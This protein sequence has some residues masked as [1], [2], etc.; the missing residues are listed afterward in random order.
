MY[1]SP[2]LTPSLAF[3]PLPFGLKFICL[4]Y[5]TFTFFALFIYLP[6]YLF[7]F[8]CVYFAFKL[9][10]FLFFFLNYLFTFFDLLTC[11]L[12]CLLACLLTYL[13]TQHAYTH[14]CIIF[15]DCFVLQMCDITE[16]GKNKQETDRKTSEMRD[17]HRSQ[18]G[19]LT[20]LLLN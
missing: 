10:H 12:A 18:P 5:F 3:V 9:F 8:L 19:K 7:L 2:C 17:R 16:S 13:H 14:F 20:V 11:L 1:E 4:T 15:A 6:L